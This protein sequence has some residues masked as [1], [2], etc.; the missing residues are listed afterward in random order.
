MQNNVKLTL[1]ENIFMKTYRLDD[2]D[3]KIMQALMKDVRSSSREI[4]KKVGISHQTVISRIKK[5]EQAGVITGYTPLIDFE[6]LGFL[7]VNYLFKTGG[8]KRQKPDLAVLRENPNVTHIRTLVGT[9]E[10]AIRVV[11]QKDHYEDV[12]GELKK[13]INERW[14]LVDWNGH[15]NLQTVKHKY[16]SKLLDQLDYPIEIKRKK[17]R[18]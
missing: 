15:F 10:A 2:T 12:V 18:S 17:R 1:W 4:A 9:Y 11:A 14:E 6:K 7:E 8:E 16:S 3:K 13:K 5:M